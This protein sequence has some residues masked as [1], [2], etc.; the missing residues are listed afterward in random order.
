M[1]TVDSKRLPE[2]GDGLVA[3]AEVVPGDA[4]LKERVGI[5]GHELHG[6]RQ[7]LL[8]VGEPT[9]P[10]EQTSYHHSE[11]RGLRREVDRGL[12]RANRL[13]GL[14]ESGV[15]HREVDIGDDRARIAFEHGE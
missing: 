14:A 7:V 1:V 6:A 8:R 9:D 2:R 5:V 15:R 3:L 12:T 4:Q 10:G 11:L 13:V